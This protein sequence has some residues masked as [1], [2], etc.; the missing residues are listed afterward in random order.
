LVN[1]YFDGE[2]VAQGAEDGWDWTSE[3]AL[4]VRGEACTSLRSGAVREVQIVYGCR[5]VVR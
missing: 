5:T 2:L 4:S 3:A 1:L